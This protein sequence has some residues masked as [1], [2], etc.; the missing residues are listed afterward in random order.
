MTW[1][2]RVNYFE[3]RRVIYFT[4]LANDFGGYV[5]G[6][7]NR[8]WGSWDVHLPLADFSYNNS[9]HSSI[10]CVPFEA[11]YGRKCRSPVLWAKIGEGSLI[12]P[13]LLLVTTDKVV[14]IK[15]KLKVARDHQKSYADKRRKP[16]EFEVGDQVLLKVL[17]WKG[18]VHFRKKGKLAPRYVGPFEIL[19]RIGLVDYRL[20]LPEELN[21]VHDTFHVSNLKKCLVDVN[22]QVPLDEIKFEK[23]LRFVKKPELEVAFEHPIKRVTCGYPW[24]ELEGNHR[25]FEVLDQTFDRLQKYESQL[26]L[27]DEKL[28]QEDVNQKLLR[29]LSPEWNTHVVLCRNKADLETMSMDDLY[30]NLKW[31]HITG[32]GKTAL[33]VGMDRTFNSQ[34]N[35]QEF[36][37]PEELLLPKKRKCDR[38]CSSTPTLPQ[39]FKIRESSR[40]TSLERHEEQIK[41]IL[42]HLDELSLDCIEHGRQHR[43]SWKRMP[44]KRNLASAASTS[45]VS[46]IN[47]ATII[48]LVVDSVATA[49]EA[50]AANMAN[51]DNTNRDLVPREAHVPRKCSYKEFMICQPF[52]FKGSKGAVGLI[53]WNKADLETMSMDDL[54]NNLKVYELEVN[55]TQVINTANGV[56]TDSTQVNSNQAE[57]GLNYALMAFS[58][59]SSDSNV[60]NDSTCSKSCL[61]TVKLIKSQN[62]QLLKDLK[63]SE[64]MVLGYKTGFESVEERL[65]FFKTNESIYLEDIK[66]LKVE[67]Q[68]KEIAI[69]DLRKKLEIAQKKDGIQLNVDKLEN[70]SKSLNKLIECQIVKNCKKGLGYENCN[71]VPPPYT[72][73]F[74]PLTP[75]FSFNGLGKFVN[76]SEVENCKAKSSKKEPKVVR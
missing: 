10:R 42:N 68:L 1:S 50:Q 5:K 28:S 19:E 13:E 25:D 31:E 57:E 30:N 61:E 12:R 11:L 58:S 70:A 60:S 49:L 21:N 44:P 66:C 76:K 7:R 62:E 15:E 34:H 32:S 72:R 27:L 16:L 63:K 75:D 20:R 17:P 64:L 6:L 4:L 54:Y 24:P 53:R 33:E 71:V 26:V 23:T 52:N 48:Q 43:R 56:S 37:L 8:F 74:M 65:K 18:V 9:Y 38:S 39:E 55:T 29:S 40:K 3:S 35:S 41:E 45:D 73:N 69:R 67:I 36:F 59:S 47:Q 2:A 46:A 22:L 51:A 14:L